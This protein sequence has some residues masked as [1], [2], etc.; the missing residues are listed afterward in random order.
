MSENGSDTDEAE[1]NDGSEDTYGPCLTHGKCVQ[2]I[3][4]DKL[5]VGYKVAARMTQHNA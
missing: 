2:D 1:L 3:G 5:S 4:N